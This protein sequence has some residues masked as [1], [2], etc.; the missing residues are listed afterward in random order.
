MVQNKLMIEKKNGLIKFLKYGEKVISVLKLEDKISDIVREIGE[1]KVITGNGECGYYM[2][3]NGLR[4]GYT[5]D[6]I[7]EFAILFLNTN[8][9]GGASFISFPLLRNE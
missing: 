8:C 5:D 4:I 3:K 6:S 2:Y 7:D 9:N 1:P